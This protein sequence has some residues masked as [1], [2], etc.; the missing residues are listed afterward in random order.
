MQQTPQTFLDAIADGVKD[1]G[2]MQCLYAHMPLRERPAYLDKI[3]TYRETLLREICTELRTSNDM[4]ATRQLDGQR[5]FLPRGTSENDHIK[6]SAVYSMIIKHL[7]L[8][9][10]SKL[11]R[12]LVHEMNRSQMVPQDVKTILADQLAVKARP[13]PQTREAKDYLHAFYLLNDPD[14]NLD[15]Y[16]MMVE[17]LDIEGFDFDDV[18]NNPLDTA[19]LRHEVFELLSED[20]ACANE[21]EKGDI[22]PLPHN[23]HLTPAELAAYQQQQEIFYKTVFTEL[24]KVTNKNIK[25]AVLHEIVLLDNLSNVTYTAAQ[26]YKNLDDTDASEPCIADA[27]PADITTALKARKIGKESPGLSILIE[28]AT[29]CTKANGGEQGN[30]AAIGDTTNYKILAERYF[31]N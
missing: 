30:K 19:F 13:Q 29:L 12:E 15:D 6:A 10:D 4:S 23:Q 9:N 5:F 25:R 11:K 17:T 18:N 31:P 28:E 26:L 20:L 22:I 1:L 16:Y 2:A 21:A 24:E 3:N 8:V 27:T 14:F 7:P